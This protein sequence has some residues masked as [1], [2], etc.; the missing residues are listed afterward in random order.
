VVDPRRLPAAPPSCDWSRG[1]G[2]APMPM[3]A[4][5][6]VG[7]CAWAAAGH[8]IRAATAKHGH[9]AQLADDDV[10]NAYRSTGW[11]PDD[12]ST[13]QGTQLIDAMRLWRSVGI[14]GHKIGGFAQVNHRSIDEIEQAIYLFGGVIV[15]AGLPISSQRDGAWEGADSPKGPDAPDSWG[16]HAMAA[17]RYDRSSVGMATWARMQ[18]ADRLWWVDYVFEAWVPLSLD[19]VTGDSPAPNGLDVGTLRGYLAAL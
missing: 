11:T 13:D 19:W 7:C 4:N 8:F 15:G 1:D 12:P 16:G 10:L 2:F 18:T 17:L 14:G 9:V 3:F 5:D 6:R